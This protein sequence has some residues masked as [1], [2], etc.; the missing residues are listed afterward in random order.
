MEGFL[1]LNILESSYPTE[2]HKFISL[3]VYSGYVCRISLDDGYGIFFHDHTS[4]GRNFV[5]FSCADVKIQHARCGLEILL[6]SFF[7]QSWYT[8]AFCD[9]SGSQS[10]KR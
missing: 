6:R 10:R 3:F 4:C 2:V 7:L 1:L 5:T 9:G 8:R